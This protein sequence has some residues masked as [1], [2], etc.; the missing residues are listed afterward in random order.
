MEE[1]DQHIG[2]PF[3]QQKRHV[4]HRTGADTHI[5][6]ANALA[7]L[8]QNFRDRRVRQRASGRNAQGLLSGQGVGTQRVPPLFQRA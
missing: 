7:E 3:F 6:S 8:L 4:M 2:K 1:T 5:N